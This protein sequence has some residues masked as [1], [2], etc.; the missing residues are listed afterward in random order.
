MENIKL[1][2]LAHYTTELTQ[3]ET[4]KMVNPIWDEISPL[5]HGADGVLATVT[6]TRFPLTTEEFGA[7]KHDRSDWESYRNMV[8]EKFKL[9]D[10]PFFRG[11]S[12]LLKDMY[13]CD[14]MISKFLMRGGNPYHIT[15]FAFNVNPSRPYTI[16]YDDDQWFV[17]EVDHLIR[18]VPERLKVWFEHYKQKPA[19]ISGVEVPI[20][21]VDQETLKQIWLSTQPQAPSEKWDGTEQVERDPLGLERERGALGLLSRI[22]RFLFN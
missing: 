10:G 7:Y 14:L 6:H 17:P 19:L 22:L 8:I 12:V 9:Y 2:Y 13:K 16:A 21:E 18:E 20:K 11:V 3:Y 1:F 4:I 5:F 15:F